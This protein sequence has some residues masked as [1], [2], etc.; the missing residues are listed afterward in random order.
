M[1][2]VRNKR[3]Q[4]CCYRRIINNRVVWCG[5]IQNHVTVTVPCF[6]TYIYCS[7]CGMA[8]RQLS[9]CYRLR[10]S[11]YEQSPATSPFSLLKFVRLKTQL[12]VLLGNWKAQSSFPVFP[13]PSQCGQQTVTVLSHNYHWECLAKYS[14]SRHVWHTQLM[15]DLINYTLADESPGAAFYYFF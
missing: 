1:F 6:I 12:V 4:G 10:Y 3:W 9:S 13:S 15:S 11:S 14:F 5:P 8:G 2:N 7:S